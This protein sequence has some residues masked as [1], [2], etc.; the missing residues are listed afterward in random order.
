MKRIL[1]TLLAVVVLGVAVFVTPVLWGKPWTPEMFYARVFLTFALRHPEMLTQMGLLENTPFRGYADEL[2]DRSVAFE[3]KEASFVD[4]EL[5]TLRSYDLAKMKPSD[6]LSA[7]VLDWF[8]SDAQKASH[9]FRFYDYPVNQLFG[10]QNN[11][12][13]FL[14]SVQPLKQKRDAEAYVTRAGK[15]GR[16]IDQTI[17]QLAVRESLGVI[18]PRFVMQRVLV[19]MR[20][21]IGEPAAKNPLVTTF[22]GKADSIP[23]LDEASRK[24]LTDDLVKNVETSVYP[25]YQ[26][27]IATCERL[28]AKT[29]DDDGVWK[30]PNGDAYYDYRL[31][32]STTTDMPADTIHALGLREVD[33]IQAQM[34]ALLREQKL[35]AEPFGKAVSAARNDPRFGFAEGDAG[36]EQILA[37]YREIL[38]ESSERCEALFDVRPK[39][40]LEVKRVP[41]FKQ[42]TSPGAYYN[43]PTLDGSRPGVF[44]ANLRDPR[45]TKRPGMRTLAYHEGIP[46]HHF[47]QAIAQETKGLPFFRSVIPFTAYDEGWALYAERLALENGFH[48][49]AYDSLGAY[50]AELFRAVRLVV[51]TGIHRK[52]WTRQQAIDY[53]VANTGMDSSAVITEIERYIV[54][55]GQAC[56][57]KVGQLAILAMRDRAKAQLGDKFD[58]KRF[59]NVV[60]TNGALPLQLLE[61]CVDDWVA[62]EQKAAGA[63]VAG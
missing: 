47:Q 19:E 4:D 33:R 30:L 51:D 36:R 31:R 40:A 11:L 45:E 12:P 55:P 24:R 13:S 50:G 15:I 1:L 53:M 23:G 17:E 56:A 26:R 57:Y 27:L 41:E 34:R 10:V 38:K 63:K 3:K 20:G 42:A 49:D 6:R 16:A 5:K 8:L 21:F 18:P 58:L 48:R 46:G 29:T 43:S 28:E 52:H 59:H 22:T 37:G 32:N 62:Q 35:P 60:L 44:Y 25:A 54:M 7:Q 39:A 9:E 2:D 14:M 61:K